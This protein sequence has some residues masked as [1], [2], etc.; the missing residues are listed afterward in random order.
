MKEQER[1]LTIEIRIH[2]KTKNKMLS[3]NSKTKAQG[4]STKREEEEM[5]RAETSKPKPT[6]V[7]TC[8]SSKDNKKSRSSFWLYWL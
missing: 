6:E 4:P 8:S 3:L 2:R 7:I 1:L 5:W